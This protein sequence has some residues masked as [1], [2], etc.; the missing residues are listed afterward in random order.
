MQ[1][2]EAV[3][4]AQS[5]HTQ[6]SWRSDRKE[7]EEPYPWWSAHRYFFRAALPLTGGVQYGSVM[8]SAARNVA[9]GFIN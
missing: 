8:V 7:E 2:L 3:S 5:G 4:M 6:F 9:G 1:L